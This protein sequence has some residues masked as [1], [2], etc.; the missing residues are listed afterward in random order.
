MKIFNFKYSQLCATV[1]EQIKNFK[2]AFSVC[3]EAKDYLVK[4]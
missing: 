2:K 4:Y 3:L 1:I